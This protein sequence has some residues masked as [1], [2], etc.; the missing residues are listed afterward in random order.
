MANYY[1]ISAPLGRQRDDTNFARMGAY[2][3]S[4]IAPA[5]RTTPES[6]KLRGQCMYDGDKKCTAESDMCHYIT[7]ER[8]KYLWSHQKEA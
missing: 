1:N 6:K 4:E 7:P 3:L 2:K 8:M 5:F